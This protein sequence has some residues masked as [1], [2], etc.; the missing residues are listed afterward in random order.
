MHYETDYRLEN[1]ILD[2][3]WDDVPEEVKMRMK[4]CLLD[5]T[6][7]LIVIFLFNIERTV[8]IL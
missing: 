1:F 4:G 3:R 5:L 2:T 7:A 6:G 8:P